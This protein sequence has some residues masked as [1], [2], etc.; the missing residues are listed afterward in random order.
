MAFAIV[1]FTVGFV[2]IS[3]LLWL[4][5]LTRYRLT[6]AFLGG[7]WGLVPDAH[8]ILD[9]SRGEWFDSVHDSSAADIFFFHHTLDQPFFREHNIELT[10][11][12]LFTLGVVFLLYDWRFGRRAR[13]VGL[14]G[15]SESVERE[16]DRL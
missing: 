14:F 5:P 13:S 12:A 1:H 3:A 9:G 6:A 7:I 11:I 4:L 8:K 2:S 16:R 15:P 10:F